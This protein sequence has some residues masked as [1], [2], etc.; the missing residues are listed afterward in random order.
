MKL[1]LNLSSEVVST[2][3][4]PQHISKPLANPE[5]IDFGDFPASIRDLV[6]NRLH[7]N[8]LLGLSNLFYID[9]EDEE[10]K[11][12]LLQ[13][14]SNFAQIIFSC[15]EVDLEKYWSTDL[16]ERYWSL[17]RSGIQSC[18][19]SVGDMS[20]KQRAVEILNPSSDGGT[21][22]PNSTNAFLVAMMYFLLVQ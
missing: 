17:V 11:S 10:I 6:A 13:L 4:S 14:R 3:S 9:P 18:D 22:S 19:L 1:V 12:E 21:N 16:G 2:P 8:R 5:K 15:P 20:L 7:L